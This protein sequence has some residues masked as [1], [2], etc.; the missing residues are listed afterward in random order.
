MYLSLICTALDSNSNSPRLHV[1]TSKFWPAGYLSG[2]QLLL[3]P[4][5]SFSA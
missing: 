1:T 5:P 2:G 4:S 3:C